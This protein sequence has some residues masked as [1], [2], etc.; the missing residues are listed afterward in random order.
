MDGLTLSTIY[1]TES[2]PNIYSATMMRMVDGSEKIIMVSS[3][4]DIITLES[5]TV[6]DRPVTCIVKINF[7]NIPS[8]LD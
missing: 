6:G 4:K 1:D 7:S 3:K 8:K 2:P 5:K